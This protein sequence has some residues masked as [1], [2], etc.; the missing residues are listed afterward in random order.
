M[1]G[2]VRIHNLSVSLDGFA[3][4]EDQTLET[5]MGHSGHSHLAWMLGTRFAKATMG[6]EGGTN[7]VD[8]AFAQQWGPGIGAEIMGAYKFGPPGLAGR[9]GVEGLVGPEPAVPHPRLRAHAQ[10]EAVDR[11]GGR[12]DVPLP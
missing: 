1:S 6:G 10:A 11:D 9:P 7:G 4:G 2:K 8:D 5:P 3:T 12:H